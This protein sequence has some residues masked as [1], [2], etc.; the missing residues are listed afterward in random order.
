[1]I[2]LRKPGEADEQYFARV[3]E[4][5]ESL[6]FGKF[7][8]GW[9]RPLPGE[10]DLSEE[11]RSADCGRDDS[12][13]FDE[14]NQCQR[15]ASRVAA[16]AKSGA[17]HE[18]LVSAIAE[19]IGTKR[20]W[21]GGVEAGDSRPSEVCA[22]LGLNVTN[23]WIVDKYHAEST[24][25]TR[26]SI[27][28]TIAECYAA[29]Q[30]VPALK[31][32]EFQIHTAKSQ[33]KHSGTSV[34]DWDGVQGVYTPTDNE[35]HIL[36]GTTEPFITPKFLHDTGWASTPSEAHTLVHES[37][38]RDH[39]ENA[40]RVTGMPRPGKNSTG[41]Q[42]EQWASGIHDAMLSRLVAAAESDPSWLNRCESKIERL[43]FYA[44]TDPFEF[45]AEYSTAV[46]LGYAK[47]D[48]DLDRMCKSLY[49]PVPK[50]AR[51]A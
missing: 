33:A 35:L 6:G 3:A 17:S 37:A 46:K 13:R 39:Y 26:E 2:I 25:Y 7:Q 36:A 15:G 4:L 41:R 27:A 16:V 1:M 48:P 28:R 5:N 34:F 22:A 14:G 20:G 29:V 51:S 11:S 9:P 30:A 44:T 45:V 19:A 31:N 21:L 43:G 32:V 47:N 18:E 23:D 38:H 8:A 49:A 12:G 24:Q 40:A 42:L 10:D 50:K